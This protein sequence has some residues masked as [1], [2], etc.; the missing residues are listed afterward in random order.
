MEITHSLRENDV[1]LLQ[2]PTNFIVGLSVDEV[3]NLNFRVDELKPDGHNLECWEHKMPISGCID[4]HE[5][6]RYLKHL[7]AWLSQSA[8]MIQVCFKCLNGFQDLP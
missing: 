2:K 1:P 3:P 8:N 6:Y 4:T 7:V 5:L